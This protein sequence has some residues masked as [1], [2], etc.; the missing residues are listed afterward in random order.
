MSFKPEVRTGTDP[1]F[2][3]NNLAFATREEAER[4]ARDLMNRWML[5][6]ECRAVESDQPVTHSYMGGVLRSPIVTPPCK[7]TNCGATD[8]VS[9]SPECHAEHDAACNGSAA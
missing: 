2:Y 1:K 8:G 4:S 6:V 9:H 3:D 7:G 5:V